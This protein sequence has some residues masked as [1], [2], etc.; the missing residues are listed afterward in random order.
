MLGLPFAAHDTTTSALTT[1]CIR[2]AEVPVWQRR[3]R[4]ECRTVEEDCG[5]TLDY[6]FLERL[7]L[8]DAYFRETLRQYSPL[9]M[10]PRRPVREFRFEG[11]RIPANAPILLFPQATHF[12]PEFFPDPERFDPLRFLDRPPP[13][14]FAFLPFG[15][16]SHMCLGMHFAAMEGPAPAAACAGNA[17]RG[18]GPADAEL[19]ADRAAGSAGPSALPP[20]VARFR[21][22][23]F[24]PVH[25]RVQAGPGPGAL[26]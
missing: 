6:E 10:V 2:L 23:G 13:E 19:P 3:L 8:M 7:P 26:P 15:R 14:P 22:G 20:L 18:A 25:G 9:Q 4:E 5:E 17:S 21:A 24:T 1:M 16:G 12:D 11:H